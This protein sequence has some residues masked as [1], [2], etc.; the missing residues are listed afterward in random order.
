LEQV[1]L[2]DLELLQEQDLPR[3]FQQ[4][5][6]QVEEVEDL[7]LQ[8]EMV[9]QVEEEVVVMDLDKLQTQEEQEIV[10]QLVHHKE[11]QEEL[12]IL[13]QVR[14]VI[15]IEMVEEVEEQA[16]QDQMVLQEHNQGLVLQLDLEE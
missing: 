7:F 1:E 12:Q 6:L 4:L 11:I 2:M 13:G 8:V 9:V 16:L 5:H 10:H 3:Y 14:L 15:K